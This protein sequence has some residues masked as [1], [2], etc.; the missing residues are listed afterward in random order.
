M[1]FLQF[2]QHV[3]PNTDLREVLLDNDRGTDPLKLIFCLK[4][5]A[6]S[7]YNPLDRLAAKVLEI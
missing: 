7:F 3:L 6:L 2:D 4:V 5:A 1:I